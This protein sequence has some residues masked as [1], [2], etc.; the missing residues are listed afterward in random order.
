MDRHIFSREDVVDR[1]HDEPIPALQGYVLRRSAPHRIFENDWANFTGSKVVFHRDVL[2]P[3]VIEGKLRKGYLQFYNPLRHL[4]KILANGPLAVSHCLEA[5]SY[6]LDMGLD[7]ACLLEATLFGVG[8]AS[9]QM[10]EG[11]RAFLE[12]RKPEFRHS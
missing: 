9:E 10:R 1:V 6:G 8:A 3:Q 4:G 5:V 12:K 7:D 11:T 2:P